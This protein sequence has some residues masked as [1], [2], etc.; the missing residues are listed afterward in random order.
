MA[1]ILSFTFWLLK[2]KKWQEIR[3]CNPTFQNRQNFFLLLVLFE[4]LGKLTCP[5]YRGQ[6]CAVGTSPFWNRIHQVSR[7]SSLN[8][9]SGSTCELDQKFKNLNKINKFNVSSSMFIVEI[10]NF[11]TIRGKFGATYSKATIFIFV[12][13]HY[14]LRNFKVLRLQKKKKKKKI[15]P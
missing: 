4:S 11:K 9:P 14:I 10:N 6:V 1:A 12:G 7:C 5:T 8:L 13:L 3:K 2:I 15:R